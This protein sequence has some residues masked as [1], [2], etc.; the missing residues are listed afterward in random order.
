MKSELI[1]FLLKDEEK[2][3]ELFETVIRSIRV[4]GV[5]ITTGSAKI[6]TGQ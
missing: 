5:G 4:T 6:T 2:L 1:E 3:F